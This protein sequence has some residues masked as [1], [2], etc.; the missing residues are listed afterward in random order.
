MACYPDEIKFI[1]IFM[2]IY[3]QWAGLLRFISE[4]DEMIN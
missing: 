2:L 3:K 4:W 1:S